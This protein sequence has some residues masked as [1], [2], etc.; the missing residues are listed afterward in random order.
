[1]SMW[2][3]PRDAVAVV[4][5][6]LSAMDM[7]GIRVWRGKADRGDLRHL[8]PAALLGIGA[9]TLLCGVLSDRMVKLV[10]GLIVLAFVADRL[11]R[12]RTAVAATGEGP[13]V[14]PFARSCGA[15]LLWDGLGG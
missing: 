4:L 12:R 15:K 6:I 1:M 7:V 11:L 3:P 13:R 10:L 9:G 5:P 2:I 8:I 14:L